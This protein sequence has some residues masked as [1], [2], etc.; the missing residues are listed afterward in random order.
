MSRGVSNFLLII[1]TIR[2]DFEHDVFL[3]GV[4]RQDR[5]AIRQLFDSFCPCL[6][7]FGFA[8]LKNIALVST[9]PPRQNLLSISD[10][11]LPVLENFITFLA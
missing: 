3:P 1:S 7:I 10:K 6:F 2:A 9:P 5:K 4:L 11:P 8:L